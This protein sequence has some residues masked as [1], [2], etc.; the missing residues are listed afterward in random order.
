MVPVAQLLGVWPFTTAWE[1]TFAAEPPPEDPHPTME[2]PMPRRK[3][4]SKILR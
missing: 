3:D 2:I 4:A 1:D